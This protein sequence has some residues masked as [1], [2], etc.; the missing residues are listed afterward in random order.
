MA[1]SKAKKSLIPDVIPQSDQFIYGTHPRLQLGLHGHRK[2]AETMCDLFNQHKAPHG[3]LLVGKQGIGKATFV[4]HLIRALEREGNEITPDSIYSTEKDAA[5]RRLEMLSN[6]NLKI[7]RRQYNYKTGK[8]YQS[9]RMDEIRE[10]RPFFQL[11]PHSQGKRYI[12]IDCLDDC[13]HGQ[14]SVP[15]AILKTLEEPPENCYFFILVHKEGMILPTIKSRC[16]TLTMTPPSPGELTNILKTIPNFNNPSNLDKILELSDGSV[17]L[18]MIY[19]D[20]FWFSVLTSIKKALFKSIPALRALPVQQLKDKAFDGTLIYS[21]YLLVLNLL[22]SRAIS[23]NAK[24]ATKQGHH[25][26]AF[27][28]G[29]LFEKIQILFTK[30]EEYNFT[31]AEILDRI[32]ATLDYYHFIKSEVTHGG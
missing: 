14:N 26:A 27:A 2:T 21:E 18:A 24:F 9:I 28:S 12:I 29:I 15:N 17:R 25:T 8:H 6:G 30:A 5:Y 19:A 1:K 11:K 22:C 13:I 16:M 20:P 10:L 4:Y 3:F 32:A 31:I 7:L 23:D